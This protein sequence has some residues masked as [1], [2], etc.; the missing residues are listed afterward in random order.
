[1]TLIKLIRADKIDTG[2]LQI[3]AVILF[4]KFAMISRIRVISVP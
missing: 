1:M 4:F 2:R 3:L